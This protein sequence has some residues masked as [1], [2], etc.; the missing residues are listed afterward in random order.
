MQRL[1]TALKSGDPNAILKQLKRAWGKVKEANLEVPIATL[2]AQDLLR[3]PSTGADADLISRIALLSPD[4]ESV[5]QRETSDATLKVA[6]SIAIGE[7]E[8]D[9]TVLISA[10]I[11]AGFS[12]SG[13]PA[14]LS[15]M[16]ADNR[17]GEAILRAMALTAS[18]AA[19]DSA[20]LQSGLA[21]LRSVGLEDTARRTA[22]QVLLLE[23]RDQG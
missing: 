5:A 16:V 18:G 17:L 14:R 2:F 4:Y 3:L 23:R 20:A 15:E 9:S 21:F 12:G 1:E 10:A 19:G 22:L 8:A 6:Q 13:A 7:P 11:E